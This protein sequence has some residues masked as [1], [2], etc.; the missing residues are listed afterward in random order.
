MAIIGVYKRLKTDLA[1]HYIVLK[2]VVLKTVVGLQFLQRAIFSGLN[3]HNV[4]KS[5]TYISSM[6]WTYGIPNFITVCE[7]FI[8]SFLFIYPYSWRPFTNKSRPSGQPLE[9]WS[10][11]AAF[12]HVWNVSDILGGVLDIFKPGSRSR[13]GEAYQPK[14]ESQQEMDYGQET[15]YKTPV[16]THTRY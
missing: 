1:G 2:L 15:S 4:I 7:M 14:P 10:F 5:S 9:R 12:I 8:F 11:V 13:D 6:D 3:G 16:P